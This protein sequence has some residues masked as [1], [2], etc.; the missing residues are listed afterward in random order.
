LLRLATILEK[1]ATV[2]D[3]RKVI[4]NIVEGN[5]INQF[6]EQIF[7]ATD[8]KP[9]KGIFKVTK[10]FDCQNEHQIVESYSKNYMA[11]YDSSYVYGR[12]KLLV[13]EYF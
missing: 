10:R 12:N 3:V 11:S 2:E 8:N 4:K 6:K 5:K 7:L 13:E 1:M 9:R